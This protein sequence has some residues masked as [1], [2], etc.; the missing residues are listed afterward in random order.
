MGLHG[1][2]CLAAY[3]IATEEPVMKEIPGVLEY[4]QLPELIV[5]KHLTHCPGMAGE[6]TMHKVEFRHGVQILAERFGSGDGEREAS[7]T[8]QMPYEPLPASVLFAL[9]W[10]RVMLTPS[11]CWSASP[12]ARESQE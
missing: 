6:L 9:G 3:A 4:E 7:M 8:R 12:L 10:F 5:L 1:R 2:G 11:L